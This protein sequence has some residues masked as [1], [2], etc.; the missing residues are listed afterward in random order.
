MNN[1]HINVNDCIKYISSALTRTITFIDID[2]LLITTIYFFVGSMKLL[3]YKDINR[4][5]ISAYLSYCAVIDDNKYLIGFKSS[6][7]SFYKDLASTYSSLSIL[8]LLDI[9]I[10]SFCQTH[11]IKYNKEVFLKSIS[12]HQDTKTGRI[13]NYIVNDSDSD[14]RFIYCAFAIFVFLESKNEISKY[15]DINK[16]KKYISLMKSYEGGYSMI[17]GGEA[18]CGVTYC[19]LASLSMINSLPK[20]DSTLNQWL[21]NRSVEVNGR[22]NKESDVCYS[23][24]ILSSLKLLDIDGYI[25]ESTLIS[26]INKCNTIFGGFSKRS[27]FDSNGNNIYNYPDIEHTYYALMSLSL[28]EHSDSIDVELSILNKKRN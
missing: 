15:F 13:Y 6:H 8:H 16:I 20:D 1:K 4:D 26:F 10:D 7:H 27:T 18:N 21:I 17:D 9:P 28:L 14:I 12:S 19:A 24:W 3:H 2:N 22:T 11:R 5:T 23:Y 25:D